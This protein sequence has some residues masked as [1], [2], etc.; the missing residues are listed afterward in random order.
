M[1]ALNTLQSWYQGAILNSRRTRGII[2]A[3]LIF[4]FTIILVLKDG[5]SKGYTIGLFIGILAFVLGML[6]Q[7]L[8]LWLRSRP[9][10]RATAKRD[11]GLINPSPQHS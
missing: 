6:N 5:I 8:W 7:T 11:R 10:I 1:P 3:I 9:A 4:L 2:E